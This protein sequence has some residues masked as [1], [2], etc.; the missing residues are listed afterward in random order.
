VHAQANRFIL[1]KLQA[2]PVLLD[3]VAHHFHAAVTIEGRQ[4][5]VTK[6][7]EATLRIRHLPGQDLVWWPNTGCTLVPGDRQPRRQCADVQNLERS[8]ILLFPK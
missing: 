4:R 5:G 8:L 1:K 7:V 2:R 3:R 6:T